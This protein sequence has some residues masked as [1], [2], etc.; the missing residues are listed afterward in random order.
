MVWNVRLKYR[1]E[2][3]S[4]VDD[5]KYLITF[6]FLI[7]YGYVNAFTTSSIFSTNGELTVT[8]TGTVFKKQSVSVGANYGTDVSFFG[9]TGTYR[10]PF[11][12][13]DAIYNAK[14]GFFVYGSLWKVLASVPIV[15]ETDLGV[16]YIYRLSKDVKGEFSYTKSFIN[17][18]SQIIKSSATNDLNFKNAY[19]WKI[20]KTSVTLDYLFGKTSDIFVTVNNSK[21]FE[22][23][24]SI[25]D[26][27]D[28]LTFDPLFSV[29]FGTQNF[30][31]NYSEN[32]DFTNPGHNPTPPPHDPT[33]NNADA[34]KQSR[35]LIGVPIVLSMKPSGTPNQWAGNVY[36]AS[37]GKT[38]TGSFTMT[39]DNTADLKGCVA[40]IF[41]KT[42]TWTRVK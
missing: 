21:Y 26:D 41:C 32:H 22:S 36:N 8:D 23:N 24:W 33:L 35:P 27:K 30:V 39:G 3:I 19:D 4:K 12:S 13:T 14:S 31:Q 18:A 16:G 11:I 28:Y 34:S 1:E 2:I 20:L 29:I 6:I 40:T 38:Y 7:T 15:D 10:Y 17:D 25:F 5:M 42:Q 37:D 9:R